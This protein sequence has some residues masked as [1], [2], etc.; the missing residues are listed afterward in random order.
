MLFPNFDFEAVSKVLFHA[1]R[2]RPK[3]PFVALLIPW[4]TAGQTL[5]MAK[6]DVSSRNLQRPLL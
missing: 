5:A 2:H 6:M 1:I 4:S 3:V